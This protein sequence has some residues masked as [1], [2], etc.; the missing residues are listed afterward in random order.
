M[1][2]SRRHFLK[3]ISGLFAAA[4]LLLGPAGLLKAGS[5]S[6]APAFECNVK[7]FGAKGDGI[8]DD[9]AALQR[10]LDGGRRI[11]VI[12]AGTYLIRAALQLDSETTVRADPNAVIRL[13]DHAGNA[14]D[15]FLLK[16]RDETGGNHDIVVEGGI[17]DGNNEHNPR[18]QPEEMP[19]YTGVGMN[20]NHVRRLQLRDLVIRNPET[21]AIRAIHLY[22]FRIEDIGFDFSITRANQDGVHLNGF[23]ERG[24]IRNLRALSP[25]ATNDDMVALNADDGTGAAF[26]SQQGTVCGPIRDIVVEH[27]RAPSAF[28]FVRLLSSRHPIEN[29][30]ISDI[31]GGCRF[32]AINMDR[33]RFPP[34]GGQ[35]RNVTLRGLSVRKMADHFSTQARA[36]ERPLIHIQS[37]VRNLRI[38]QFHRD[39]VEQPPAPTLVIENGRINRLRLEGLD[40]GQ[41]AALNAASPQVAAAWFSVP[42]GSD[43]AAG[44]GRPLALN[45][46]GGVTLPSGGFSLLTLDSAETGPDGK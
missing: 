20:F 44:A 30:T 6:A 2:T 38:E 7:Q 17:W 29:V 1:E 13:A 28:T 32:Y 3:A 36:A 16:N 26:V 33:W 35:I 45:S 4:A 10:A 12:P 15:V 37:A 18:G 43:A 9:T 40:S 23:C 34:G 5:E 41:I 22:D 11:V 31:V 24:V 42:A 8:A 46:A 25:Y 19:C 21:Y 14:V 39:A 27:L